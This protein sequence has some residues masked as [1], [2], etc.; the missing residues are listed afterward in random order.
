[1]KT[2]GEMVNF[3]TGQRYKPCPN[4]DGEFRHVAEALGFYT[5]AW[6]PRR[7]RNGKLRWL[8]WIERHD[9]H[10]YTLGNRAH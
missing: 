8:T 10:T 1:M 4:W 7:C 6:R 5:F 9:D 3:D 2:E